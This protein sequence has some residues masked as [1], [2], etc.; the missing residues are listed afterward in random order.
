VIC[1]NSVCGKELDPGDHFQ[2]V[3]VDISH[4]GGKHIM[5]ACCSLSCARRGL[6]GSLQY[7]GKGK[8]RP[9]YESEEMESFAELHERSCKLL[10]A[11]CEMHSLEERVRKL[12]EDNE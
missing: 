5:S 4:P 3:H 7:K 9:V 10:A 2:F 6:G 12:E 11:F 8:P 1:S